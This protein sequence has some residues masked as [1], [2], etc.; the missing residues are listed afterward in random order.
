YLSDNHFKM[1]FCEKICSA[2]LDYN[3][4]KIVHIKSKKVGLINRLIQLAIIAYIIGE[5]SCCR[6]VIIYKKG[7]Q[8]KQKPYSSVTTK[9]KGVS[10]TNLTLKKHG[11]FPFYSGPHVWD[12]ADYVV[13]P[14]ESN[15]FFVIT[16]LIITPDQKQDV[17]PESDGINGVICRN[18]SDCTPNEPTLYGHGIQT[19]KCVNST[20]N[21]TVQVCQIFAWCPIELDKTPMP[22]FD[23]KLEKGKPL[24]D[25]SKHTVLVKNTV[26]FPAFKISKRN[27]DAHSNTAELKKCNYNKDTAPL[28]PIFTLKTI[29][30][31]AG[32]DFTNLAYKG[33]VMGIIINWD[34]DF[35]TLTYSCK[36]VYSFRR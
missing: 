9:L 1:A 25:A 34:C 11:S 16:N 15:A 30:E 32:E 36:P 12:E 26:Q 2:L 17:C 33:G 22:Q 4:S 27:I 3:T 7:Y 18:D 10:F 13:P 29:V 35:D 21:S 20:T 24:L 6:Y 28:C 19:G 31:E 14:E 23:P 8:E 5:C